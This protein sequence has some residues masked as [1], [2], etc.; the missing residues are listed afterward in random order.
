[1]KTTIEN[2]NSL[3][4]EQFVELL[5]GVYEHSPWMAERAHS[6][7]PF[8]DVAA[9][10]SAMRETLAVAEKDEQLGLIR[11]HPDLAGIAAVRGELTVESTSEQAGA[12]LGD[13][14][15]AEFVK[16]TDLNNRYKERFDFPFIMA[17][18]NATKQ[19]I[20]AGFKSRIENQ[21]DDEFATALEQINR[22]A[23][24]RIAD[25]VE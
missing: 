4:A 6:K 12:G 11:A 1:M 19:Q 2:I 25:L 10:L 7:Q 9:M 17:V 21:P 5:G 8:A 22:I 20:I 15:E 18:K 3:D 24:F 16:F 13:L 14:T 23:S